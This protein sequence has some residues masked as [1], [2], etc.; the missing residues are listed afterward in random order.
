MFFVFSPVFGTEK[1]MIYPHLSELSDGRNLFMQISQILQIVFFFITKKYGNNEITLKLFFRMF[2]VF[3]S[4]FGIEN[5]M[6]YPHLSEL[7]DGR[8]GRRDLSL[9]TILCYGCQMVVMVG[10]NFQPLS[11]IIKGVFY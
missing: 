11:L 10:E 2:F 7:S 1:R 8:D 9:A 4:V 6:I 5:R 3:S